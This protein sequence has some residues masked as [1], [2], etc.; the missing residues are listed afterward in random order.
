MKALQAAFITILIAGSLF[1]WPIVV[2][3]VSIGIIFWFV[4]NCIKEEKEGE[5]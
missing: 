1:F 2:G 4:Y 3:A 5:Q